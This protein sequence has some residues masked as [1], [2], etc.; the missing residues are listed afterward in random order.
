VSR[1]Q[2]ID[3][4]MDA[5]AKPEIASFLAA[6]PLPK[7]TK[8]LLRIVADGEW[9]DAATAHVYKT[10][11]PETVRSASAAF[12]AEVLFARQ[13]DPYRALGL[14]A[15]APLQDVREHKR[16]L[17]KWLHPDRNPD[18]REQGYLAKVLAAAEAIEGG[19][20][21]EFGSAAARLRTSPPPAAP[22]KDGAL[23][24]RSTASRAK[25]GVGGL[26]RLARQAVLTS[27]PAVRRTAKAS[28]LALAI[29][30]GGL[31]IWRYLMDEPI[32]ASLT[33]Y[34]NLVLGIVAWP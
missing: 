34:V 22:A 2:A 3:I 17:L 19:R 8:V 23:K 7:G 21:H 20:S 13:T 26:S 5:L 25:R 4:A 6:G 1:R 11:S 28:A 16:L 32:G 15:G 14:P 9:R 24:K 12:L 33:R 30:L 10:H 31:I 29:L 18:A 27:L